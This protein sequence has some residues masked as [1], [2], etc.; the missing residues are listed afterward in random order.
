MD[1]GKEVNSFYGFGRYQQF[2]NGFVWIYFYRVIFVFDDLLLCFFMVEIL[3]QI[4]Q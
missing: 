4:L 3:M 2:M 1:R